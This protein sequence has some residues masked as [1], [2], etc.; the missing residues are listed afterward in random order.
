MYM[1]RYSNVT[2]TK[3]RARR[4]DGNDRY[5]FAFAKCDFTRGYKFTTNGEFVDAYIEVKSSR[6]AVCAHTRIYIHI[7]N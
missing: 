3:R 2:V 5:G 7:D 1:Q 6:I 4:N